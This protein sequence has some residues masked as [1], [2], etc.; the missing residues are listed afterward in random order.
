MNQVSTIERR[1]LSLAEFA[2]LT[3][4]M[5]SMVALSIDIM[6]PVVEEIAVE[7]GEMDAN[8]AQLIIISLFTGL[9]IGQLLYGPVSDTV[10]RKPA[11]GVGFGIFIFGTIICLVARDF[12]T[13]L[14]GRFLQGLGAAAPRI[15]SMSIV[16]DLYSGREMAK[17]TSIIMGF[18]I[19]VPALA[20]AI[21]QGIVIFAPWRMIFYV[22]L[23]QAVLVLFW[24]W[25]RQN[26][27]LRPE[28]RREFSLINICKR[29]WEVLTTRISFW[30]TCAAGIVFGA[31]I[32]YL[33]TSPQLFKDLYGIDDKF[34]LYFGVLA[35]FIGS[36]SFF[37]ARLVVR[38]GMRKLCLMAVT[39]QM[40]VSLLFLLLAWQQGGTLP[41]AVFMLWAGIVFFMMGFLFGNFN[42]IALEPLGHIAGVGAAVV[43]SL[44]TFLSLGLGRMIGAAYDQ[45]LLPLLASFA[46]LGLMSILVMKWADRTS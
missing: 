1:K 10:G 36:A 28:Y 6:L 41:L 3:A 12:D 2:A 33:I 34:P 44:S 14:L 20:P 45:S 4:A 39:V 17:V 46:I 38:L 18:F 37:N 26:E 15:V 31:F 40:I 29:A 35:L 19:L 8:A 7:M 25:M 5:I 23:G 32:G 22:L 16:R 43:G 21:G 13:M 24:F 30:Y 9:A 11:I 42:A 27:T